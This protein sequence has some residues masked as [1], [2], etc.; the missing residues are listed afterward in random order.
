MQSTVHNLRRPGARSRRRATSRARRIAL[1]LTALC[2]AWAP[3]LATPAAAQ[4]TGPSLTA[5]PA[6]ELVDGQHVLIEGEGFEPSTLMEIFQCTGDS[7]GTDGCDP[8][9][10]YFIDSDGTGAVRFDF[11]VD[12]RIYLGP[13]GAAEFDC[14]TEPAGCR[15]GVGFLEDHESS[16]FVD[17]GFDPD[18]PLS[19]PVAATVEPA[20]GLTDGATVRV[21]A[22][23]LSPREEAWVAQCLTGAALRA[24][25]L[26]RAVRLVPEPDGTIDTVLT[27]HT[28]FEPPTTEP[29]DCTVGAGRCSVAVSWG[30]AEVP[31]R[32]D[33]VPI[34]F[35]T[36]PP[37][38]P[39]PPPMPPG[40]PPPPTVPPPAPPIPDPGVPGPPAPIPVVEQPTYTG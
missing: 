33:E 14:R 38:G 18:A 34:S 24:C 28:T 16:V 32:L 7:T 11:T 37:G 13:D 40:G 15:I 12:A 21:T 20:S 2:T 3:Q 8:R 1:V 27:V 31:D 4:D 23:N 25:D 26:D 29:V 30:F 17:L 5:T 9:N 36:V 22:A 6:S 35:G 19:P 10:A 39:P